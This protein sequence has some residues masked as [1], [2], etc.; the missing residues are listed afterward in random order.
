MRRETKGCRLV[1]YRQIR[2]QG[3]LLRAYFHGIRREFIEEELSLRHLVDDDIGSLA[4]HHV[5]IEAG[6][7]FGQVDSPRQM[8]GQKRRQRSD[9]RVTKDDSPRQPGARHCRGRLGPVPG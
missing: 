6:R 2:G 7:F 5:R 3:G 4:F 1:V 9:I 8:L